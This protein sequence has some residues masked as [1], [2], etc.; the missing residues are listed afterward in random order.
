MAASNTQKSI[1]VPAVN[2]R[3]AAA[4]ASA[5]ASRGFVLLENRMKKGRLPGRPKVSMAPNLAE[6]N[7]QYGH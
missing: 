6:G 3:F 1:I 5:P 2:Q 4:G 7:H